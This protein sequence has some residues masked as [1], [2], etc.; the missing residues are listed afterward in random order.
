MSHKWHVPALG[1]LF[2]IGF[3]AFG[4]TMWHPGV[5][6][7]VFWTNPTANCG[8][9]AM[10]KPLWHVFSCRW[11]HLSWLV[12][13]NISGIFP[14]IGNNHPNWLIYIRGV[15]TTNQLAV[16]QFP[17][18]FCWTVYAEAGRTSWDRFGARLGDMLGT[19][20]ATR[21]LFH[22]ELRP[23]PTVWWT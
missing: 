3:V 7:A 19:Q 11:S 20:A 17:P 5:T 23:F 14:Y 2:R 13:W 8:S 9:M 16:W 15:Q 1:W 22:S 10:F 12:V 6:A 18:E 21:R 4:E